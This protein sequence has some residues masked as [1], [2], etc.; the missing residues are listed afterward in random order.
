M[1]FFVYFTIEEGVQM[2]NAEGMAEMGQLMQEGIESGMITATGQLAHTATHIRLSDGEV[3]I[4]DG[5]F[6]EGTELISGFTV[7]RVVSQQE[8]IEWVTKLRRCMG[9]GEL[10]M[11]QVSVPAGD[12]GAKGSQ[13]AAEM[14][15]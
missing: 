5:P 6:I 11:A 8:A 7:I 13:S 3:S 9:D 1:K 4:T 2:P 14:R 10:R 15:T 12:A